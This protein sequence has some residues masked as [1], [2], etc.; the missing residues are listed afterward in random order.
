MRS[1]ILLQ[2]VDVSQ[3]GPECGVGTIKI[4][5]WHR[6][7]SYLLTAVSASPSQHAAATWRKR[8]ICCCRGKLLKKLTQPSESW[9][10]FIGGPLI[11]ESLVRPGGGGSCSESSQ[12]E[13]AAHTQICTTRSTTCTS[14][15]MKRQQQHIVQLQHIEK[16]VHSRQR[17]PWPVANP[18]NRNTEPHS[19]IH[20]HRVRTLWYPSRY[21]LNYQSCSWLAHQ[22]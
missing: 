20:N 17:S 3:G 19:K 6:V 2:I 16:Y 5:W 13:A 12:L 18:H 1:P 15:S 7:L 11:Q 9:V 21:Y 22:K 4:M 14:S 10:L 8:I